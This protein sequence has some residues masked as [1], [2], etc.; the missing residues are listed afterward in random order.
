MV[1]CT[2]SARSAVFVLG[3]AF[4]LE[5]T[6][7][8]HILRYA[9]IMRFHTNG[10][11]KVHGKGFPDKSSPQSP[12]A[13]TNLVWIYSP[14]TECWYT[15]VPKYPVQHSGH[16]ASISCI[17]RSLHWRHILAPYL[18]FPSQRGVV[19]GQHSG[20]MAIAF[21]A[22]AMH[23]IGG[24]FSNPTGFRVREAAGR[25]VGPLLDTQCRSHESRTHYFGVFYW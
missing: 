22:F 4:C 19:F 18:W 24:D 6:S 5:Y 8:V 3:G 12:G 25:L 23:C 21:V 7:G 1:F 20:R 17:C 2:R 15:V 11:R 9:W 16:V 14:G 10:P 13:G